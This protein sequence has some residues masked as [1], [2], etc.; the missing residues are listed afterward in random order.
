MAQQ[1]QQQQ[2]RQSTAG[3]QQSYVRPIPQQGFLQDPMEYNVGTHI[4][5]DNVAAQV[6]QDLAAMRQL[7]DN[8]LESVRILAA[9]VES[10]NYSGLVQRVITLERENGQQK[11]DLDAVHASMYN[12][13][14]DIDLLKQQVLAL[15][16]ASAVGAGLERHGIK[17]GHPSDIAAVLRTCKC[18]I[19]IF[20][21]AVSL[22]HS[23]GAATSSH[24]STLATMKA[25]K[26]VK[27]TSDL[28][29]RVVTSFRTNL[30]AILYGGSSSVDSVDEYVSLISRLKSYQE[31]HADD[32]VSGASQR[33][34]RGAVEIQS[35]VS[36]LATTSTTDNMLLRLSN[37]TMADSVNFVQRFVSF[38]D[39]SFL[40]L[41]QNS[42]FSEKQVWE[43]LVSFI[44]QV[45][46]DMRAARCIIQDA[47]EC[48]SGVLL[49][50]ILKS[51]E[52]MD[53]YIGHGFKKHPSL[54][55]ILVQKML[56]SSPSSTMHLRIAALEKGINTATATQNGIKSRLSAVE[57]KK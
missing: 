39:A 8:S 45:F 27:L 44:E 52:V 4:Q 18:G 3:M 23:I 56:K 10:L 25:Q 41:Q 53:A 14:G 51:H 36:F 38:M 17:F 7:L 11:R 33:M 37:G 40:E 24:K 12:P 28:E 2:Q 50:G 1:R 55:G 48:D 43:L 54:N 57:S 20:H 29:A 9:K 32:G 13:S 21:D 31:W 46:E 47:S 22:L 49:W 42:Y 34:L 16:D 15:R 5:Q 35:R 26:D 30:P 19:A 6:Q